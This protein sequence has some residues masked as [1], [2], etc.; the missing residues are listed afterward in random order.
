MTREEYMV[1]RQ[2]NPIQIVYEKYKEGFDKTKH[3]PFLGHN[4]FF[5]FIQM[6]CNLNLLAE[7]VINE[8]DVK[9]GVTHLLD[10]NGNFIKTL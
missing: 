7:K 4:E 5:T 2:N 9:F 8:Y 1:I 10:K 6:V 3:T